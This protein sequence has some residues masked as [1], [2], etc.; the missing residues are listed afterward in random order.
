MN[1]LTP[2]S[3]IS[4]PRSIPYL[5]ILPFYRWV[6]IHPLRVSIVN[7]ILEVVIRVLCGWER[8]K[9]LDRTIPFYLLSNQY[10]LKGDTHYQTQSH[11]HTS[12]H[13]S[14]PSFTLNP[15]LIFDLSFLIWSILHKCVSPS[16][17]LHSFTLPSSL[18][19][20]IDRSYNC[21]Q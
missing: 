10:L 4:P 11:L 18:L 1:S 19:F 5:F 7:W 6:L 14:V 12:H 21:Y 15:P 17:T 20:S 16:S 13:Y 3:S 8:R 2:S 9:A